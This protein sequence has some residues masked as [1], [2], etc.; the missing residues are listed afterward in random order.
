PGGT[1]PAAPPGRLAHAAPPGALGK[2][3]GGSVPVGGAPES[4][5]PRQRLRV[6]RGRRLSRP[7][8][9]PQPGN[10]PVPP[11]LPPPPPSPP[12]AAAHTAPPARSRGARPGG[13]PARGER[14]PHPRALPSPGWGRA[15]FVLP[16]SPWPDG[17]GAPAPATHPPPKAWRLPL[18]AGSAALLLVV[19]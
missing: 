16:R 15:L 8:A 19:A 1:R 4:G 10:P 12:P 2:P 6:R 14:G 5:A 18:I 3:L 7:G 9:R 11:P 17:R 13:P